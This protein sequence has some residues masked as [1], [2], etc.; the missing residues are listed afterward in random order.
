MEVERVGM[1]ENSEGS[2]QA[3]IFSF[4]R[5]FH[6]IPEGV[7]GRVP[8]GVAQVITTR[9]REARL[10][11]GGRVRQGGREG[12]PVERMRRLTDELSAPVNTSV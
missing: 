6:S 5:G 7:P 8:R 4:R 9:L 1:R 2:F 12:R 11:D 3:V 10:M